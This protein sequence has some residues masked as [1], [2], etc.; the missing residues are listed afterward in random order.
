VAEI[1]D[2]KPNPDSKF[3]FENT[4]KIHIIDIDPI[5]IVATTTI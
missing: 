2:K 3:D 5:A 4:S 1:K